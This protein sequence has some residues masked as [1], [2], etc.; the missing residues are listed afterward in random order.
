[1]ISDSAQ[2]PQSN[3]VEKMLDIVWVSPHDNVWLVYFF[4]AGH[5]SHSS[6]L[7]NNLSA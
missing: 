6:V 1:M 5:K 2:I 7:N 3:S 4:G